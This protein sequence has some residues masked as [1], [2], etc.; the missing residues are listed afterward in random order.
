MDGF[1]YYINDVGTIDGPTLRAMGLGHVFPETQEMHFTRHESKKLG[2]GMLVATCAELLRFDDHMEWH[3]GEDG[4]GIWV[5]F[6]MHHMPGPLDL[7]RRE[8]IG[9]YETELGDC[10]KWLIPLIREFAGGTDLPQRYALGPNGE[11]V[12]KMLPQ[13]ARLWK[14]ACEIHDDIEEAYRQRRDYVATDGFPFLIDVLQLNY[15]IGPHEVSALGLLQTNNG[16]HVLGSAIDLEKS[17]TVWEAI[18]AQKKN[19]DGE[20]QA[21]ES[22]SPETSIDTSGS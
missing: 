21:R 18:A 9:G 19:E 15:R 5:G 13:Y 12:T 3:G 7:Q 17:L 8:L 11:W 4:S 16:F 22:S 14:R 6:R 10:R 20:A 1:T 2:K